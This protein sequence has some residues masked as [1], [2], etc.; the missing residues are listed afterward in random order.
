M[1]Y[2]GEDNNHTC[3]NLSSGPGPRTG[4]DLIQSDREY[5]TKKEQELESDD[6]K[7][8]GMDLLYYANE[9]CD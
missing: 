9:K 4:V 5:N 7:Y 2:T 3:Y 8:G 6:R 1:V